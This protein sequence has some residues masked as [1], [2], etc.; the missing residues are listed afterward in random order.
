MLSENI[1]LGKFFEN[2]EFDEYLF[3]YITKNNKR[4]T[5]SITIAYIRHVLEELCK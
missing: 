5:N 3:L 2:I 1:F 4:I